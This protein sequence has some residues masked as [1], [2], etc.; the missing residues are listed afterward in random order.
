[1]ADCKGLNG[2]CE[3]NS[4]YIYILRSPIFGGFTV[5]IGKTTNLPIVRARELYSGSTG[6]P[7]PFYVY[8]SISVADCTLAEKRAHE[9]LATYRINSRREFFKIPPDVAFGFLF[10]IC[11]KINKEF[12]YPEPEVYKLDSHQ[13]DGA[14]DEKANDFFQDNCFGQIYGVDPKNFL[15]SPIGTSILTANQQIRVKVVSMI[16]EAILSEEDMRWAESFSR[17]ANPERELRIWENMAKAFMSISELEFASV[18]MK[19]EAFH[20]CDS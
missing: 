6:V 11:K 19:S 8:I 5:K 20:L 4:G 10:D 14:Y 13:D 7:V 16:F 3:A 12:S 9:L 2:V 1:M 17:D 18:S 15:S